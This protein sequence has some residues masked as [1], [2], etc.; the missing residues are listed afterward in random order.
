MG[1]KA[2]T[3][4]VLEWG[5]CLGM[6]AIVCIQYFQMNSAFMECEAMLWTTNL[7]TRLAWQYLSKEIQSY[8]HFS[9][10]C[11]ASI[12]LDCYIQITVIRVYKILSTD[13]HAASLYS[14]CV[15]AY[16]ALSFYCCFVT[17][18]ERLTKQI[19]VALTE[20]VQPA[21]VGV[22]IEATWV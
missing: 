15:H 4:I 1:G 16:N 18:Q 21:G 13:D 12:T 10:M 20:A 8:V 17:V 2:V 6:A 22:V 9:H 14:F 3:R 19:A 7:G 5:S 11:L